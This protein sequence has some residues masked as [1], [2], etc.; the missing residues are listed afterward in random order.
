M[1]KTLLILVIFS[2]GIFLANISCDDNSKSLGNFGIDMATVVPEG[3]NAYSLLLDNGKRLW[4]AASAVLYTPKYN[5]RVFLNYTILSDVQS[6]Y[7]HYIKVN[8]IWNILTKKAIELNEQNKDSIGND[9]VK[10]NA[11]W[12]GGDYLN[13]SF[14]FN[15]G[16]VKPHAINLVGNTLS[17]GTSP[18]AIELEFRHNS[19]QSTRSKLYEGFVC[20][21]LKP[22]RVA[23]AD[24]VKLSIKIKG[25]TGDTTY[26][27]IYR[28]NQ[29]AT[30][31]RSEMPIPVISSNEYY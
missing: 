14:M 17:P 26:D 12:V 13:I 5:Q 8:D 30:Q 1:K 28:Y 9:P 3:E 25:W 4:P 15:Y 21:D 19:Y 2:V 31:T 22:F 18:D 10:P 20:F 16:G 24:S 7:D 6:G 29:P 27:V 11:V 23:D